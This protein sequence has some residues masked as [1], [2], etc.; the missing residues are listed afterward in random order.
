MSKNFKKDVHDL[1]ITPTDIE[2]K[3]QQEKNTPLTD[4]FNSFDYL[5]GKPNLYLLDEQR[6]QTGRDDKKIRTRAQLV[7]QPSL[8]KLTK[9][10]ARLQHLSFNEYVNRAIIAQLER[11]IEEEQEN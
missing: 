7:M 4:L 8:L 6:V 10:A 5:G 9:L 1:F 2:A 3:L 11:D